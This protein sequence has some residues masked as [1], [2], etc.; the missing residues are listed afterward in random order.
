MSA[1]FYAGGLRFA[2][3]RCSRCCRHEPGYVFL[4]QEDLERLGQALGLAGSEVL[5]RYCRQVRLGGFR[6]VS[7]RETPA[8]D[9]ILWAPEGC[10]VYG[11][12]PLQCRSFPFWPPNLEG[13]EDWERLKEHCPGVG[14]GGL[15]SG[16]AIRDWLEQMRRGAFL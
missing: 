1:S 2:C 13:P 10:Q 8:Y 6:R 14:A 3:Q 11:H 16:K 12:R 9:C 15:H 4:T 5:A 7:L